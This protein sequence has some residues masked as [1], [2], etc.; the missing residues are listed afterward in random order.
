MPSEFFPRGFVAS[1][2]GELKHAKDIKISFKNNAALVHT[3]A[4]SPAGWV[5]GTYEG[6]AS[7]TSAIGADGQDLDTLKKTR[8]VEGLQLRFKV[9]G[10]TITLTGICTGVDFDMP[11]D[12]EITEAL[13]FIGEVDFD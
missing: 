10:K 5:V 2:N 4:A 13:E 1:G 12:K 6:T 8:K 9:P 11:V 7:Y 3:N